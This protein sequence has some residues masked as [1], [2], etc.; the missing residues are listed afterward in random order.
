MLT[1]PYQIIFICIE[2]FKTLANCV[3]GA[4]N[5]GALVTIGL[6]ID[7]NFVSSLKEKYVMTLVFCFMALPLSVNFWEYYKVNNKTVNLLVTDSQ[8][9]SKGGEP[10]GSHLVKKSVF[11]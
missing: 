3:L 2:V 9:K 8:Q 1:P 5:A 6:I 10:K 4:S 11:V 7:F